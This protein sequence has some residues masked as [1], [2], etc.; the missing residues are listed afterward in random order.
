MQENNDSELDPL[1]NS[2]ENK[3]IHFLR[4]NPFTFLVTLLIIG[5]GIRFTYFP[6]DIP[7]TYDS[8]DYFGYAVKTSQIGT[9]PQGWAL[10]NNGWPVFVSFFFSF[11]QPN[12]FFEHIEIQRSLSIIISSLTSIPVYF[13]VS[14][15]FKKE[16]AL[17]ASALFIFEPRIII[18][19]LEG[20]NIEF[21]I[22]LV[23]SGISLF[24]S[25]NKKITYISFCVIALSVFVRY[26][27]LLLIIPF[28]IMFF[29][30][31][32][33]EKMVIPKYILVIA[34][35]V[36]VLLP[37]SYLRIEAVG[38][39]GITSH[40]LAGFQYI[41]YNILQGIPEPGYDPVLGQFDLPEKE[42]WL[43]RDQNNIVD[44]TSSVIT[45]FV[46]NF[47]RMMI[48]FFVL[49][50]LIAF[51][52]IIKNKQFKN[53]D[54]RISTLIL[55]GFFLLIPAFYSYGRHLE[56]T[57]Y[58]FPIIPILCCFCVI[59]L[60]YI[61][62]KLYVASL[63]IIIGIISISVFSINFKDLDYEHEQS[64]FSAA[65]FIAQNSDGV[66]SFFPEGRYIKTADLENNWPDIISVSTYGHID[67]LTKRFD[68]YEQESLNKFILDFKDDGLTHIFVDG[69]TNR[70]K[71]LN[72]IFHNEKNYPYLIKEYDSLNSSGYHVKIY[73]ID[74]DVFYRLL[75]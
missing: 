32:R 45:G 69:G 21:Y 52:I 64:A 50:S 38:E 39:D 55:C 58:I 28:S 42:T 43:K 74:Y 63:I 7:F 8:L 60:I 53:I 56:E 34:I 72:D 13:I 16:I 29:V 59:P 20:G 25:N 24:L 17:V 12:T 33:S 19:S 66:N 67:R 36:L 47:S 9:L 62:K 65:K 37:M 54:W 40:I 51:F 15:F 70:N 10:A 2:K 14:K 68:F 22:F 61:K 46:S 49:P 57:R 6:Y 5:I 26:E 75:Q 41:Q 23:T 11:M 27:G 30:K 18:N 35:F 1:V 3:M 73:K 44:F 31:F 48:P 71:L 4:K